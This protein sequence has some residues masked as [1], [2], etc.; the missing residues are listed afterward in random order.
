MKNFL[1]KSF[2]YFTPNFLGIC[3]IISSAGIM[4]FSAKT[5]MTDSDSEKEDNSVQA[6]SYMVACSTAVVLTLTRI[7]SLWKLFNPQPNNDDPEQTDLLSVVNADEE[8]A[9]F[10]APFLTKNYRA[11]DCCSKSFSYIAAFWSGMC[12][13]IVQYLGCKTA[14]EFAGSNDN[15]LNSVL[16]YF[17]GVGS[18]ISYFAFVFKGGALNN[19]NLLMKELFKPTHLRLLSTNT[20][21]IT[22]TILSSILGATANAAFAYFATSN[23]LKSFPLS[24]DYFPNSLAHTTAIVDASFIFYLISLSFVIDT[25]KLFNGSFSAEIN[26]VRHATRTRKGIVALGS[27]FFLMNKVAMFYIFYS[28]GKNL[29]NDLGSPEP[30]SHIVGAL[31]SLSATTIQSIFEYKPTLQSLLYSKK[32][33]YVDNKPNY[34]STPHSIAFR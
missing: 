5:F 1:K 15:L 24:K 11:I 18:G 30:L 23:G 12:L 26:Q 2:F 14:L 20:R 33:N 31:S 29:L 16:S 21:H 8:D 9:K 19:V 10:Q 17:G 28:S 6:V 34:F 32:K 27:T 22:I 13:M 7:P 3:D 25:H 4:L